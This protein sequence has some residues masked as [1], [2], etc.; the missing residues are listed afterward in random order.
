MRLV[1]TAEN[2]VEAHFV[3]GLLDARGITAVVLE[4]GGIGDYPSVWIVADTNFELAQ[5][6]VAALSSDQVVNETQGE[7]RSCPRCKEQMGPQF[8]ECWKCGT[9]YSGSL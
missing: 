6:T 1:Y 2:P 4:E 9:S 8:T 7:Y 3:K 5:E